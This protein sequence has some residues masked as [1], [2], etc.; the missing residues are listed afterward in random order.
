M[1]CTC[2]TS[3][4]PCRPRWPS[5]H[6]N[7][8]G[9]CWSGA[10]D[11]T[12]SLARRSVS[13]LPPHPLYL[14]RGPLTAPSRL[15]AVLQNYAEAQRIKKIADKLEDR[16][17]KTAEQQTAALFARKEAQFRQQQQVGLSSTICLPCCAADDFHLRLPHV[18]GGP[19]HHTDRTHL[20]HAYCRRSSR[21]CSSASMPGGR[22]T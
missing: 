5:G 7:G 21:R 3:S 9:S 19:R 12:C 4:E 13:A 8:V 16:E 17:K 1:P 15:A 22:N 10:G 14:G 2:W 20:H 11:S 18:L 6:P